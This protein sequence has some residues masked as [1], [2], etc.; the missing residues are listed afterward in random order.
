MS[1]FM[2]RQCLCSG[3]PYSK[4]CSPL[5]LL[6]LLLLALL[7]CDMAFFLKSTNFLHL[8]DPFLTGTWFPFLGQLELQ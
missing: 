8:V 1:N 6:L 3:S 7:P 4:F 2:G 5:L